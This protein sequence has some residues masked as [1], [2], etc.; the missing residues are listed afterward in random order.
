QGLLAVAQKDRT[1]ELPY[2]FARG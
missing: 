2:A 1:E